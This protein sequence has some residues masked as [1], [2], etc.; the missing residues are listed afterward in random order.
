M[1]RL[2]DR[3]ETSAGKAEGLRDNEE[4]G[5]PYVGVGIREWL[6]LLLFEVCMAPGWADWMRVAE[7]EPKKGTGRQGG[8]TYLK[9]EDGRRRRREKEGKLETKLLKRTHG[10]MFSTPT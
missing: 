8:L 10:F 7:V 2:R 1:D 3:T 9:S 5:M 6:V 4:V